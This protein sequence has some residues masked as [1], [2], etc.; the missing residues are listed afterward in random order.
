MNITKLTIIN[1]LKTFATEYPE[2]STGE[3]LYS[4]LRPHGNKNRTDKLS[5][6]LSLTDDQILTNI[7]RAKQI[8]D[9]D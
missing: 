7:E 5:D 3:M 8:E 6:L 1:E 2:I 4:F 9:N